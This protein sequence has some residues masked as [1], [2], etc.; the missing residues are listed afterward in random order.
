MPTYLAVVTVHGDLRPDEVDG[1]ADALGARGHEADAGTDRVRLW[2]PGEA[3]D[4]PTATAAALR[5]AAEVLDGYA[6]E[7]EVHETPAP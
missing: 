1:M 4:L 6:H 5:H 3:P 7:V 2:V